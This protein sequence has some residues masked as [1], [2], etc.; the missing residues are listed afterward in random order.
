MAK[1]SAYILEDRDMSYKFGDSKDASKTTESCFV[2][3]SLVHYIRKYPETHPLECRQVIFEVPDW[4]ARDIP[5]REL[6]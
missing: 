3:K 6:P 1:F 2:P 4:K 5:F